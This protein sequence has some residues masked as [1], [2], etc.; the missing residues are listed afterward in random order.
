MFSRY[1]PARYLPRLCLAMY[2]VYLYGWWSFQQE[3]QYCVLADAGLT[4]GDAMPLLNSILLIFP[5]NVRKLVF[6]SNRITSLEKEKFISC[7]LTY[8]EEILVNDCE[9]ETI[10]LVAFSELW[11]L[12][13]LSMCGNTVREVTPSTFHINRLE[14]C[15]LVDN[16]IGHLEVDLL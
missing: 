2:M 3:W 6:D 12:A 16:I 15:M 11:K 10:E 13:L 1:A 5:T 14:Y 7:G 8:L 4:Q 9:I